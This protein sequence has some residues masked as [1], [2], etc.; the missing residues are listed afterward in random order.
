MKKWIISTLIAI[1]LLFVAAFIWQPLAFVDFK[2][3][4]SLTWLEGYRYKFSEDIGYFEKDT[5]EEGEACVCIFLVHGLGDQ[6]V[7]WHKLMTMQKRL[8]VSSKIVAIDLPGAGMS[9]RL[10]STED[11]QVRSL[12]EGLH[13]FVSKTCGDDE[14][15][16]VGN[17]FGGWITSWMM[18]QKPERYSQNV[19]LNP[20]G[21]NMPYDH[22]IEGLIEPSPETVIQ[23]YRLSH[24]LGAKTQ[25][26]PWFVARHASARLKHFPVENMIRAQQ[27]GDQFLDPIVSKI[28]NKSH[29][30]WGIQDEFLGID[31]LQRYE[32]LM[33]KQNITTLENCAHVPQDQC[34]GQIIAILNSLLL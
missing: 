34:P 3:Y 33:G 26:L 32:A 2:H 1:A 8:N 27:E 7:T 19:L 16:L 20:A 31:H 6:A 30:I 9:P 12:A 14:V 23:T 17:S 29:L 4:F 13:D 28:G 22:A 24:A 11:Y 25:S 18:A 21:L 15:V 10:P 5:C